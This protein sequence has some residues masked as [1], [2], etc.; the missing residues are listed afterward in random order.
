MKERINISIDSEIAK[1]MRTEAIEKFGSLRSFSQ[2]IE[3]IY[4]HKN[5]NRCEDKPEPEIVDKFEE[6]HIVSHNGTDIGGMLPIVAFYNLMRAHI[7]LDQIAARRERKGRPAQD[8]LDNI[9]FLKE[10]EDAIMKGV[11]DGSL[12]RCGWCPS[13]SGYTRNADGTYSDG[14]IEYEDGAACPIQGT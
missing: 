8:I 4:T 2:L 11:C 1:Q 14:D 13:C 12:D 6:K 3:D 5:Q 7:S 9:K 10:L